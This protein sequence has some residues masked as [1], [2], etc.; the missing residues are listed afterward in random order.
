MSK[1]DTQSR[2]EPLTIV[3]VFFLSAEPWN[4]DRW[5]KRLFS[6]LPRMRDT[7]LVT[8]LTTAEQHEIRSAYDSG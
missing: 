7:L 6:S 5:R 4:K 8:T 2:F 1:V 3:V